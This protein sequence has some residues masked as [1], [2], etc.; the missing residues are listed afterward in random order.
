M[1]IK[2]SFSKLLCSLLFSTSLYAEFSEFD[3]K[4]E[5]SE[6]L[7]TLYGWCSLEKAFNLIDLVLDTKADLYVEIGVYGGASLFPVASAMKFLGKGLAIGIDPWDKFECIRYY[8]PEKEALDLHWWG[9]LNFQ[10]IYSSY[11]AMIEKNQLEPYIFN[12]KTTS[13]DAA[14]K[15][16]DPIDI[17]Y[18][19]G[20]HNEIITVWDVL[21]YFPLVR[22]EGYII[23]NDFLDPRKQKA[24]SI[25][26]GL[27]D[28]VKEIEPG[29]CFLYRKKPSRLLSGN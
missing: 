27:C 2:T 5:V 10:Y 18:I 8:D 22:S 19:D 28:K 29:K 23:L 26:S 9:N 3:L 4:R 6:V 20:N 1:K 21:N 12:L 15:I 7:P 11:L 13:L 16:L 17:L 25:L 24:R 14:Q